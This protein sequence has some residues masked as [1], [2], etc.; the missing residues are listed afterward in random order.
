MLN[1]LQY[2]FCLMLGAFGPEACGILVPRPGIKPAAPVLAGE[3]LT[4]GPPDT[5][6]ILVDEALG[7]GSS[8]A[9]T[10]LLPTPPPLFPTPSAVDPATSCCHHFAIGMLTACRAPSGMISA[11]S[12]F[13][14]PLPRAEF[15]TPSSGLLC[16]LP[17]I[18]IT[19]LPGWTYC[20]IRGLYSWEPVCLGEDSH[21]CL[22]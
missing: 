16:C 6:L 20:W 9:M 19:L 15:I 18:S 3:V 22:P 4:A 1:L 10:L 17:V 8:P 5:P 21:L 11:G 7:G 14:F 13:C 2:C 12:P